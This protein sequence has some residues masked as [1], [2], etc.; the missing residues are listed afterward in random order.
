MKHWQSAALAAAVLVATAAPARADFPIAQYCGGTNF[1]TCAAVG[2]VTTNVS[3]YAIITISVTNLGANGLAGYYDSVFTNIGL[4]NLPTGIVPVSV[5]CSGGNAGN[6]AS[7][8]RPPPSDLG[9][10]GI[11]DDTY[12]MHAPP[13]PITNGLQVGQTISFEFTFNVGPGTLGDIGVGIHGQAGPN[14]CSTK[15]GILNGR[16]TTTGPYSPD[17]T[18]STVPEPATFVL[19]G[20]GLLGLGFVARRRRNGFQI[21]HESAA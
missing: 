9:G 15:L 21:E 17:C 7:W 11:L 5:I 16:V 19:L 2:L 1:A 13:S 14:G 20:T 4:M 12:G 3:G 6:C 18:G 10:A 8:T